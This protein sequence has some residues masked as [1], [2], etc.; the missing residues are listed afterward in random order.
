MKWIICKNYI[1]LVLLLPFGLMAHESNRFFKE[2]IEQKVH[3]EFDVKE[4]AALEINN[5]FGDVNITSWDQ[6]RV[7]ID[8]TITVRGHNWNKMEERLENISIEFQNNPKLVKATTI[9]EQQNNWSW[10]KSYSTTDFQIDYDIKVPVSNHLDISNDYGSIIL[11]DTDGDTQIRCDYGKLILGELRSS[12]NELR[13]DY[14]SNSSIDYIKKGRIV[15]DYSGFDLGEAEQLSLS[16]DYTSSRIGI[17]GELDF[18]ADYGKV[19][20]TKAHIIRG[21]GDYVTL[22]F[23]TI[24]KQLMVETDYCS[25]KVAHLLPTVSQVKIDA[26]YTGIRLGLDPEWDFQFEV[27]LQYA[28]FQSDFDL[29]FQKKIKENTDKYYLGYRRNPASQ[30]RLDVEA[31]Y[32]NL[33]FVHN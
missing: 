27:D 9:I 1:V 25:F 23:G 31:Q 20:V 16:A 28:G 22:R 4:D 14:T 13:F 32:G 21:N 10:F 17:V 3:K 2:K 29:N 18:E 15:S 19:S 26:D 24:S 12:Q 6:N 8:V 11:D 33:K 5:S 7:V 30:N